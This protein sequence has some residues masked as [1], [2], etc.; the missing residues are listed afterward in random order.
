[1]L[2][3]S[4][5]LK[6]ILFLLIASK[7][8]AQS[9]SI[10]QE[11]DF[12]FKIKERKIAKMTYNFYDFSGDIS[13]KKVTYSFTNHYNIYGLLTK[14]TYKLKP[15]EYTTISYD[16]LKRQ[17]SGVSYENKKAVDKMLYV[18]Q[19]GYEDRFQL[20]FNQ[21][22]KWDTLVHQQS[23]IENGI[24]KSM[25]TF[26]GRDTT[27][28]NLYTY[29]KGSKEAYDSTKTYIFLGGEKVLQEINK[30]FY[31]NDR[32]ERVEFIKNGEVIISKF[33]RGYDENG[34]LIYRK[35]YY[36]DFLTYE[37]LFKYDKNGILIEKIEHKKNQESNL[38]T[39]TIDER[40]K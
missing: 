34:N 1:M 12:D 16:S 6:L 3:K 15:N 7:S 17:V 20:R 8:N 2:H 18:Y 32:V 28:I 37:S 14:T 33:F 40:Y 21:K 22:L 11:D 25:I 19:E 10:A 4:N 38:M 24:V 26:E 39:I 30:Y 35:I 36:D 29:V 23:I 27:N 9:K 31:K 13:N 5:I